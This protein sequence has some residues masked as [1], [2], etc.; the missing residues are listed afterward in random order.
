MNTLIDLGKIPL[1]NNL[2]DSVEQSLDAEEFS[3]KLLIDEDLSIYLDTKIDPDKMFSNYLY[4]SSINVP[5][6][7]HCKKMWGE[8]NPMLPENPTV[9]DV[10]GNDGALLDAF[11]TASK[12]EVE[13][14]NFDA[15]P[16]FEEENR[17]KGI[18]FHCGFWGEESLEIGADCITSTNVFQHNNDAEKFV[19]AISSSMHG[20]WVLEFPY[21]LT[22][23]KTLQFDQ[24]YHEHYYYWLVKPLSILFTKYGLSIVSVSEHDIHGGTIRLISSNKREIVDIYCEQGE[25]HCNEVQSYIDKEESFDFR[26][27]G[28]LVEQKIESDRIFLEKICSEHSIAAF[29]AA[30]KGCTYLSCINSDIVNNSIRYVIDD[31][32]HKQNKYIPGTGIKIVPRDVLEED[33]PD[34]LIVLAHNF[35][36]YIAKSLKDEYNGKIISMFPEVRIH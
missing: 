9:I 11:R 25:S 22:T 35:A 33:Q 7:E 1:V 4:R 2:C 30:A 13:M 34:Y 24:A 12:G 18:K 21:F 16:D 20:I 10:G 15:C 23:A 17:S 29:G 5:Y 6:I 26:G 32:K 36:E 14:H 3:L 19:S 27:W 8:I 31:T 28:D